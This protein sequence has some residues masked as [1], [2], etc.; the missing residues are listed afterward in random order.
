MEIKARMRSAHICPVAGGSA[1]Y[2]YRASRSQAFCSYAPLRTT[3]DSKDYLKLSMIPRAPDSRQVDLFLKY[4]PDDHQKAGSLF[5]HRRTHPVL[6][7]TD[8]RLVLT[9]GPDSSSVRLLFQGYFRFTHG[10]RR[11]LLEVQVWTFMHV[12]IQ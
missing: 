7:T 8:A 12:T 1:L 4:Y 11:F 10:P 6:S 5:K 3:T 2:I 9:R